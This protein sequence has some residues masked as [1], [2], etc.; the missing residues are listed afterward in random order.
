M[1]FQKVSTVLHDAEGNEITAP[2]PWTQAPAPT[3]W[4]AFSG[5]VSNVSLANTLYVQDQLTWKSLDILLGFS[6][7][8]QWGTGL[9]GESAWSPTLG[10]VYALTDSVSVY[11]NAQ[12][13][14]NAQQ[15]YPA[16]DGHILPPEKGRSVE[17]G[18]KFDLS[19]GR[20][21]GTVAAFHIEE[22]NIATSDVDH[23]GYYLLQDSDNVSRGFEIDLA[24]RLLLGWNVIA[25]YTYSDLLVPAAEGIT[26]LPKHT[27]SL[28]T[29]YD[30][31]GA[32]W[33]GWGLGAGVRA[34]SSYLTVDSA[35][36]IS[37]IPGQARIDASVYYRARDWSA[38]LGVK[39][40]FDRRLYADYASS[41]FV[42]VVPTRLVYLTCTYSF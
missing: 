35:G 41:S 15:V 24:G 12:R 10:L 21:V 23:P 20:L 3:N 22:S 27:G 13:S 16:F 28:W 7:G 9:P 36:D 37:R 38:T 26:Q 1:S 19:G 18:F 34:R 14:F 30:L 29:T 25:S 42:E 32:R 31:Q 11:A 40:V 8:E 4:T 6:R 33:R 2:I 5:D 39:N 17:A